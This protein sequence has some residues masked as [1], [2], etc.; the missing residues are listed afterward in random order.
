[1]LNLSLFRS[2]V[3]TA[4]NAA[5][6][7]IFMAQFIVVFLAPLVYIILSMILTGVGSGM[8]QTPNNSSIMGSVPQEHRGIASGTLA[9]MRNIGMVMGV[10]I[11]GALF[12]AGQSKAVARL[13]SQ[14]LAASVL[15]D[16]SFT[17]ALRMT[18]TV[19][20]GVALIATVASLVKGAAKMEARKAVDEMG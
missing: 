12:S 14:K 18:F 15:Q 1:M 9:T 10:A 13:A 11:S 16:T 5:A 20:A 6:L 4:G 8:F 7:F 3:F 2:R 19:A 17:Y